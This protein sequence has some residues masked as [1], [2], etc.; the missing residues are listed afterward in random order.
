MRME[1]D[2]PCAIEFTGPVYRVFPRG[3]VRRLLLSETALPFCEREN[4][5]GRVSHRFAERIRGLLSKR[6]T[7]E[8]VGTSRAQLP[9]GFGMSGA[10]L[11]SLRGVAALRGFRPW[12]LARANSATSTRAWCWKSS[13]D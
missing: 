10:S 6:D 7:A 1:K 9:D 4:D 5:I 13:T 8:A 3:R 12:D 2:R 11:P